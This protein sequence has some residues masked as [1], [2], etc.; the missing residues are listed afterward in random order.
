M[1]Y[2]Y[3]CGARLILKENFN[4]G[5]SEGL[6][7]YCPSCND[8]RFSF[9]YT[10]VS[11]V[12]YN[13]DYSKTLL[14][15]Q[16][17]R[18]YNVLVAGYVTP[19]ETLE[20]A[21]VREIKEEVGLDVESFTFNASRYFELSNSLICNFI[22]TVKNEELNCNPEVDYAKW[23]SIEE[24]QEV[25]LKHGLAGDFFTQSLKKCKH[26]LLCACN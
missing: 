10:A 16:Y 20:H 2:C 22:V 8:F 4:C 12:I 21:L 1:D 18:D 11:C 26:K 13:K 15:K 7:P 17:G 6:V 19:G 25:I 3:K 24:A 14:I 5:V 23:Y 9:S